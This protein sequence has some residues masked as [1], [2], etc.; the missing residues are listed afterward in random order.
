MKKLL[1]NNKIL[2]IIIAL[3]IIIG[4][5]VGFIFGFNKQLEYDKND[6]IMIYLG[7][8]CEIKDVKEITNQVLKDKKTSIKY[9]EE[10]K[11][12]V[13]IISEE[14]TEEEKNLLIEKTNEKFE[15]ENTV[16]NVE[17]IINSEIKLIDILKQYI[18]PF[19]ITSIVIILYFIIMY[20]KV[21][22]IKVIYTSILV[23]I[24]S[25]VSLFSIIAITR[26]PIGVFTLTFVLAFFI[27]SIVYLINKFEKEKNEK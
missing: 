22:I 2:Y 16:D 19:V 5:I 7:N 6:S 27:I 14:I 1:S 12:T 8:K 9:V 3:I 13:L 10:F 17:V 25:Q 18:T 4:L 15:I 26:F 24:I 20:K 11:D 23:I 21:G